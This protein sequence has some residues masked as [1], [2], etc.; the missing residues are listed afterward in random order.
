MDLTNFDRLLERA[1]LDKKTHQHEAVLWC[2]NKELKG[3]DVDNDMIIKGG[4]IADEMGLGKTIQMLGTIV[5]NFMMRTLIVLPLVLV[6][7][8]S[9]VILR[10]LGHH[11]LIYHGASKKNITLENLN[12]SAIVLT[13]YGMI[14][15]NKKKADKNLLYK[16]KWNRLIFD[17]AHHLR[18]KKT[19][20][21]IGSLRLYSKIRW[22]ITGTPIQNS[23][24]D[25][26]SICSSMGLPSI[27]YLKQENL[28]HL[29][30]NFILRRTKSEAGIVIPELTTVNKFIGWNNVKEKNLSQ[31]IH[32]NIPAISNLIDAPISQFNLTPLE[33]FTYARQ[34]CIYPG[35]LNHKIKKLLDSGILDS[36]KAKYFI[37]G[38]KS[39][40]KLDAV[41]GT[42]KERKN[43]NNKKIVFCHYRGEID[44][45]A[46]RLI[47]AG[48]NISIFDGRTKKKD[49]KDKLTNPVDVLILQIQTA[50][51]GLN[52]QDYNEVYFVSPHWNPSIEDQAIARCHRIGQRRDVEVFRFQMS[53]EEF[54]MNDDENTKTLEEYCLKVQDDKRKIR[55]IMENPQV[56]RDD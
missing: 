52:L 26:F 5:S 48:I 43:N 31:E 32:T 47:N 16:V 17:E 54:A 12:D 56:A 6:E 28:I 30:S 11:V 20:I 53:G 29:V 39:S 49:R 9:D 13:T 21:H 33:A 4:L 3:V 45:I 50:C 38:T 55:E 27:Y 22:L 19:N 37:E 46:S 44:E 35:L 34:S 23:K 41:V 7:Q 36:E 15:Y 24:T 25:F 51:E 10:T 14:S 2:I 42:I 8:W 1:N 18:N 40:S